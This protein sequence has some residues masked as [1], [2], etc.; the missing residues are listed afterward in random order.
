VAATKTA[1]NRTSRN[2]TPNTPEVSES[3]IARMKVDELRRELK[4]RGVKGT[5]DLKKPELVNKLVK[6]EVRAAKGS[7]KGPT[8]RN[9]TPNTPEVSESKIARMKASELRTRLA[10]R[11]V[12]GTAGMKKPELVERFIK[13]ELKSAKT[14]RDR[15]NSTSRNDTP[16]TPEVSESA[17]GRMKVAELRTRLARQGIDRMDGLKKPELVK[18]LVKSLTAKTSNKSGGKRTGG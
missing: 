4:S 10:R 2:D 12:K 17:I 3:K 11:G 9:D 7:R 8:S 6:A 16:N 14:K 5:E 18:K 15:K 1:R 13:A